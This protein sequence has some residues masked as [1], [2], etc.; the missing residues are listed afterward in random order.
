MSET[1][2]APRVRLGPVAQSLID[3]SNDAPKDALE[4]AIEKMQTELEEKR[5]IIANTPTP[6]PSSESSG[7]MFQ[8][9][10]EKVTFL[11]HRLADVIEH[12]QQRDDVIESTLGALAKELYFIRQTQSV[13][14]PKDT[15]SQD[16]LALAKEKIEALQRNEQSPAVLTAARDYARNKEQEQREQSALDLAR[17][18]N[19]ARQDPSKTLQPMQNGK[20]ASQEKEHIR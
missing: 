9:L 10:L 17:L 4:R 18:Q 5:E 3:G 1:N 15:A 6:S 13:F 19:M 12:Q 8:T 7:A 2:S 11:E 16:V 14:A 20:A